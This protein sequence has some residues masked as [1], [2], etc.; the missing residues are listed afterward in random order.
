MIK[1]K[2]L[3]IGDWVQVG[4]KPV[5]VVSITK[6]KIGYHLDGDVGTLRYARLADVEPLRIE[7]IEFSVGEWVV[8]GEIRIKVRDTLKLSSG[9]C[10]EYY[11]IENDLGERLSVDFSCVHTLQRILKFL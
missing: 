7:E 10:P 2:N 5:E 11:T 4:G 8:N 9:I 6:R 1:A 3:M